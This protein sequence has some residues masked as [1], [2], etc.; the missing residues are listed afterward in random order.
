MQR[1]PDVP[2]TGEIIDGY[3]FSHGGAVA[4]RA[5]KAGCAPADLGQEI[6]APSGSWGSWAKFHHQ[7]ATLVAA[8]PRV[9]SPPIS[10]TV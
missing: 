4:Y 9:Q 5:V 6:G 8:G 3:L 7:Y 2:W 1:V 10:P